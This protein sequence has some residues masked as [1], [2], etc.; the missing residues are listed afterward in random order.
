[1]NFFYVNF[2]VIDFDGVFDC[3]GVGYNVGEDL[4]DNVGDDIFV[5][6]VVDIGFY[7]GIWFIG[8]S[9]IVSE[10]CIIVIVEDIVDGGMDRIIEDILLYWVYVKNF[11]E[12]EGFLGFFGLFRYSMVSL[13]FVSNF[14]VGVVIVGS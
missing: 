11:V 1:M 9:L 3:V 14:I 10:D 6:I 7:Y 2:Y 8:I 13:W 12:G 4:F 5:E